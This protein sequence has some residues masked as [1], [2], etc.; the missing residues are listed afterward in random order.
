MSLDYTVVEEPGSS[1]DEVSLFAIHHERKLCLFIAI[2]YSDVEEASAV[3]A[4]AVLHRSTPNDGL[5]YYAVYDVLTQ[6]VYLCLC[7]PQEETYEDVDEHCLQS[8]PSRVEDWLRSYVLLN[9][10]ALDSGEEIMGT[11]QSGWE[12][13]A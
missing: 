8:S 11:Q 1:D 7:D 12:D 13:W 10:Q 5:L 2:S 9:A 6:M 4:Q 3:C